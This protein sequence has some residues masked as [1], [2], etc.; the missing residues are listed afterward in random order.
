MIRAPGISKA[1]HQCEELV[2]SI[3]LYPTLLAVA[4]VVTP[5]T[6]L[7]IDGVNQWAVIMGEKPQVRHEVLLNTTPFHG[8]VRLGPWK[9]VR[10]GHISANAT[11]AEGEETFELFNL[12]DDPYEKQDLS[13]SHPEKLAKLKDR[14][15]KFAALAVEPNIPPNKMPKDFQVPKVW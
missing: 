4:A 12:E 8:A 1:G 2:E 9:L 10:N 5:A 7:E 15:Q 13:D 14:L 6:T 3:D 11:A